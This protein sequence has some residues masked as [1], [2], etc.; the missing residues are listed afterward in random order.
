[1]KNLK[2]K[3]TLFLSGFCFCLLFLC[4]YY[5]VVFFL[6]GLF[7]WISIKFAYF[8]WEFHTRT[9]LLPIFIIVLTGFSSAMQN[10]LKMIN[11]KTNQFAISLFLPV[12]KMFILLKS[13]HD[14]SRKWKNVQ[15]N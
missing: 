9:L 10:A 12:I 11:T 8:L 7:F 14:S 4:F 5:F 1:M 13:L 6:F 15:E 2:L 3:T